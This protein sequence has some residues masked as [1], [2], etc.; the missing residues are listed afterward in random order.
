MT[1]KT[2]YTTVSRYV[3]NVGYSF[4]FLG[5]GNTCRSC[6]E[7]KACLGRLEEDEMYSIIN[8]K[9]NWL[10]CPLLGEESVVVQVKPSPRVLAVKNKSAVIGMILRIKSRECVPCEVTCLLLPDHVKVDKKYIV[11]KVLKKTFECPF[12]PSLSLVEVEPV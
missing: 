11:Q 6:P 8:V 2:I 12:E 3:A 5:V 7:L 4:K 9:N 1:S 10:N